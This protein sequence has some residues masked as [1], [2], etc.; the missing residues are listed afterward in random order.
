[1]SN[2]ASRAKASMR[3]RLRFGIAFRVSRE[4]SWRRRVNMPRIVSPVPWHSRDGSDSGSDP[5]SN[6]GMHEAHHPRMHFPIGRRDNS[7][8]SVAAPAASGQLTQTV[9]PQR[10]GNSDLAVELPSS[11][12]VLT[13]GVARALVRV[14]LKAGRARSAGTVHH[15]GE[16]EVLAS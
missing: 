14:V 3:Q 13:P 9:T 15:E 5:G 16:T 12:P 8:E 7:A 6:H 1:M 10:D 4:K 11:P 2:G